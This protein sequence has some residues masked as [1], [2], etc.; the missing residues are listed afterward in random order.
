MPCKRRLWLKRQSAF[1]WS[2]EAGEKIC[3]TENTQKNLCC[4]AFNTEWCRQIMTGF[5][6]RVQSISLPFLTHQL[7]S[8]KKNILVLHPTKDL[9][10]LVGN[11]F[12]RASDCSAPNKN[13]F[14]SFEKCKWVWFPRVLYK[15]Q[16]K[17][18]TKSH[19]LEKN[20]HSHSLFCR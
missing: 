7:L 8:Q 12:F 20:H 17:L 4:Y 6:P 18:N 13:W 15:D 10:N 3:C 9:Q 14:F 16:D 5:R 1:C 19:D 11:F 2:W